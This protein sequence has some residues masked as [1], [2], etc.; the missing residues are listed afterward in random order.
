[1]VFWSANT[2]VVS[3]ES[4]SLAIG[5]CGQRGREKDHCFSV[6]HL[7]ER[8]G[9]W[10]RCLRERLNTKRVEREKEIREHGKKYKKR[11]WRAWG[12]G[13]TSTRVLGEDSIGLV[14]GMPLDTQYSL[15]ESAPPSPHP[16]CVQSQGNFLPLQIFLI[17]Q[18]KSCAPLPCMAPPLYQEL[19][20][21]KRTT[22]SP[23]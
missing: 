9:G 6:Q 16:L 22:T 2:L 3:P 13:G 4:S 5:C 15:S 19:C 1:M 7:G 12:R 17:F 18:K 14:L 10:G 11:N 23:I 8:H 20:G 21:I